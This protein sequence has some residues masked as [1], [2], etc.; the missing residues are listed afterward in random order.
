MSTSNQNLPNLAAIA[1]DDLALG[2]QTISTRNHAKHYLPQFQTGF[3]PIV[4]LIA[5]T[6]DLE[7]E[8]SEAL[9]SPPDV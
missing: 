4:P 5:D 7:C 6:N 9:D 3:T 1:L 8:L 2:P